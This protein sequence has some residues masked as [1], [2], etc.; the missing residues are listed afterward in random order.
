VV[1]HMVVNKS[2]KGKKIYNSVLLRESYREGGK[3]KKRTIANLS[4]CTPEEIAA[5]RLALEHR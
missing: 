2:T 3:V 4:R 5:I 1:M